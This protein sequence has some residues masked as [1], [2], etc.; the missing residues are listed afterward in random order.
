MDSKGGGKAAAALMS[1][2]QLRVSAVLKTNSSVLQHTAWLFLSP[3][4][5]CFL[6][7]LFSYDA[8]TLSN[9]YDSMCRR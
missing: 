4:L 7:D 6:Q 1:M 3:C 8:E 9:T 2:E 5:N